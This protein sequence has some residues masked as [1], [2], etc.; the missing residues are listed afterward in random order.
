MG[1]I[2]LPC[3]EIREE[4]GLSSHYL[5]QRLNLHIKNTIILTS[6]N[7]KDIQETQLSSHYVVTSETNIVLYV[8]FI[9]IRQQLPGK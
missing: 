5:L 4:V 7:I 1:S 3:E 2:G 9:S 6:E 8:D